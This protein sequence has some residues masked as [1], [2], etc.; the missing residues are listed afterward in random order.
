M[1]TKCRKAINFDLDTKALRLY[2]NKSPRNAYKEIEIF[3]KNN[4]FMHRQWSGYVSKDELSFM[5]IAKLNRKLFK[6]FPWLEKCARKID[7]T[8]VGKIYDLIL[9]HKKDKEAERK[10]SNKSHD[11]KAAK[12]TGYSMKDY[13]SAVNRSGNGISQGKDNAPAKEDLG[14]E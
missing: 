4:G 14:K 2:Y 13:K 7:V 10:R 3:L 9:L 6:T 12:Q 11:K 8:N 1:S 5:Q